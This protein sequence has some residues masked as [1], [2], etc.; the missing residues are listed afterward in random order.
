AAQL[1]VFNT[2]DCKLLLKNEKLEKQIETKFIP[3]IFTFLIKC[4]LCENT[5]D[6]IHLC[7]NSHMSCDLCILHCINFQA[8]LCIKCKDELIPCYICKEGLCNTCV[9]KCKFCSEISCPQHSMKCNHCSEIMCFFCQEQCAI[10]SKIF[11][12]PSLQSCSSCHR[13]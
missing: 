2:L 12:S 3:P 1:Y 8:D 6:S 9:G 7:T 5:T 10:C 13:G 11:C 4:E